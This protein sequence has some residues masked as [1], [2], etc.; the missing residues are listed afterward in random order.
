[1]PDL[2]ALAEGPPGDVEDTGLPSVEEAGE[3]FAAAF[4]RAMAP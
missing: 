3:I 4:L 2:E 1:M